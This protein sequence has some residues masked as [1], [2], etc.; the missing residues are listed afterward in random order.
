MWNPIH[1]ATYYDHLHI[2]RYIIED[3][4]ANVGVTVPKHS[5]E[6]EKDPTNSVN[7]PEDRIYLLLIAIERNNLKVLE[8]LLNALSQ[9]WSKK[10]FTNLL[11]KLPFDKSTRC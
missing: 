2:I 9:F 6:S 3:L 10:D 5:A 1:Y 7:F 11:S 8:Y 4:G